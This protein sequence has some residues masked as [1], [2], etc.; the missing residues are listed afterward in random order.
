M[1]NGRASYSVLIVSSSEKGVRP[2]S[3]MLPHAQFSP[4]NFVSTAGEAKRLFLENQSDIVIINAPLTDDFGT[5]LA[6]DLNES[7]ACVLLLVGSEL[8]EAVT[9]RVE[10]A[11]VMTLMKPCT[12]QNMYQAVKLLAAAH[13]KL[14]AMREKNASL[15]AKMEEIR[16]VNRAKCLLIEYL[17]MTEEN[18]HK[19]IEKQAM[20]TRVPKKTVAVSIIG[21]YENNI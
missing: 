12:R 14:N 6:L 7:G 5:Q 20:D 9:Y 13:G 8:F 17:G 18:A 2:V 19:Y 21:T 15:N 3:D 10:D 16:L 1:Q 11:G 4:V